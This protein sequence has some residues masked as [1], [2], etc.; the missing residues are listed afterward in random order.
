MYDKHHWDFT[1]EVHECQLQQHSQGLM[2]CLAGGKGYMC[3]G[4]HKGEIL[5]CYKHILLSQG[6]YMDSQSC[7]V[8]PIFMNP[9]KTF[10]LC[11]ESFE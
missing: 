7:L 4:E 2:Q 5:N 9:C 1:E 11:H 8:H 6:N 3:I 10:F